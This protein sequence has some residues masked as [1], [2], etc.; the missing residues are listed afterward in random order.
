M[1]ERT[2]YVRRVSGAT[3]LAALGMSVVIALA[4]IVTTNEAARSV[5]LAAAAG[6]ALF[7]IVWFHVLPER[8]FGRYRLLLG[9]FIAEAIAFVIVAGTG[10][11]TSLYFS[12]LLLPVIVT[13]FG[14][15]VRYVV[16]VW[17]AAQ[18]GFLALT[19][20][21]PAPADPSELRDV[22]LQRSGALAAIALLIG[23][24]TRTM[25]RTRRALQ[26]RALELLDERETARELSL[27]DPLTG[28]YNRRFI[29]T[30]LELFIADAAREERP[31]TLIALDLDRLKRVN[32][33]FGHPVG[34]EV[35]RDFAYDVRQA[36][37]GRDVV[38]RVG[39]DEFVVLLP[40]TDKAAA[41]A[42][43]QRLRE[44]MHERQE[45][46]PETAVTTSMGIAQWQ[47]GWEAADL[48]RTADEA[49]Y[50]AKRSGRDRISIA[51][52]AAT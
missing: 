46:W 4:G 20:L 39:G 43:A 11:V 41:V 18:L 25:A 33:S 40:G 24:I 51:G 19:L 44:S 37:R 45:R 2:A 34:D 9:T 47:P 52:L 38:A 1:R 17:L 10:G 23:V 22:V 29:E 14:L 32:D 8:W 5:L 31:L 27:R 16:A 15:R 13:V 48:L 35:L 7:A 26:G 50:D 12:Y 3:E 36:V 21:V 30:A 6:L 42:V 28:T 49:L